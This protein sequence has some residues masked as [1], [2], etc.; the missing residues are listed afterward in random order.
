MHRRPK[1]RLAALLTAPIIW[2]VIAY[3]GALASLL[4][5]AF[6]TINSFTGNIVYEFTFTNFIEMFTDVAYKNVVL[7]TVGIALVVTIICAAL[8]LPMAFY[9]SKIA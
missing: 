2:L 6:F 3:L 1:A 4:V 5:T 8:A 9:M 7:R